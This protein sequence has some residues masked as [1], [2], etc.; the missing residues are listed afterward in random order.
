MKLYT[1][2]WAVFDSREPSSAPPLSTGVGYYT[3]ESLTDAQ[4]EAVAEIPFDESH[5]VVVFS[6][7]FEERE[8]DP[9]VD[10]WDEMC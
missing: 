1:L 5:Q 4:R 8:L 9:V 6:K 3:G 2:D 10:N 7:D